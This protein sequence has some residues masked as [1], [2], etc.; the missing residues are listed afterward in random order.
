MKNKGVYV[1]I[2]LLA[3]IVLSLGYWLF[4]DNSDKIAGENKI[5]VIDGDTFEY[6]SEV[7]RLVCVD[8]PETGDSGYAEASAFLSSSIYGKELR[9]DRHGEDKYNRTL[10]YVYVNDLFINKEIVDKG[11]GKLFVYGNESC[12]GMK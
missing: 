2:I 1:I 11:Y 10:A 9:I 3:V 4:S 7:I 12:E 8:T 5:R 6:N